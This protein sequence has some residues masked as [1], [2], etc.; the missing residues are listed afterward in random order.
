MGQAIS[1]GKNAFVTPINC[2]MLTKYRMSEAIFRF[3]CVWNPILCMQNCLR[4]VCLEPG[5]RSL[6]RRFGTSIN[7]A[8]RNMRGV[9]YQYSRLG[10]CPYGATCK[11]QHVQFKPTLTERAVSETHFHNNGA[12]NMLTST[13]LALIPCI[14]EC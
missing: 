4:P 8:A 6:G 2:R 7:M 13:D 10:I 3:A 14:S 11:F 5:I 12:Q 9:C 1:G